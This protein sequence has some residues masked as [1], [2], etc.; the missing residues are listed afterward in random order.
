MS[1]DCIVCTVNN[2]AVAGV[3]MISILIFRVIITAA[4]AARRTCVTGVEG[5]SIKIHSMLAH[6]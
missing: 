3:I 4:V 1:I 2:P 6:E 5:V